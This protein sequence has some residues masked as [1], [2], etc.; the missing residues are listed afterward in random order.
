[1]AAG[2]FLMR[3]VRATRPPRRTDSDLS[4]SEL[5]DVLLQSMETF[6]LVH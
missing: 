6:E 5:L 2:Q 4:E 1:M 3:A